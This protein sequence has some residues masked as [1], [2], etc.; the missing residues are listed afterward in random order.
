MNFGYII[1]FLVTATGF[2]SLGLL[3][4]WVFAEIFDQIL[5]EKATQRRNKH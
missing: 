4:G 1:I 2:G 3:V 5:E